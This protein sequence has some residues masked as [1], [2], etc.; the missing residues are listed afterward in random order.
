MMGER[1][2]LH[3]PSLI[4]AQGVTNYHP[5]GSSPARIRARTGRRPELPE[6]R[7]RKEAIS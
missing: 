7:H 2:N 4:I 6:P 1:E 3:T 5:A